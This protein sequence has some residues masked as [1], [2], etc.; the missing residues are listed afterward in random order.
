[1]IGNYALY[2]YMITLVRPYDAS[3]LYSVCWD[4][5][6]LH[7]PYAVL[8]NHKQTLSILTTVYVS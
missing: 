4:L 6:R 8:T 3:C 5:V 7:K 2:I 1:V